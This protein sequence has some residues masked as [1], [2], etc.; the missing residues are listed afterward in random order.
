MPMQVVEDDA[1]LQAFATPGL[2]R[3]VSH[4]QTAAM[5]VSGLAA[6]DGVLQ[7]CWM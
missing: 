1:K 7:S 6:R 4:H 5:T 3:E 2:E